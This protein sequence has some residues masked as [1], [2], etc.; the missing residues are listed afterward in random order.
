MALT[1]VMMRVPTIRGTAPLIITFSESLSRI[2]SIRAFNKSPAKP[3]V[4]QIT[5]ARTSLKIGLI[6]E[7]KRVKRRAGAASS[8]IVRGTIKPG[9]DLP[10]IYRE[11]PFIKKRMERRQMRVI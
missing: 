11:S 1:I 9:T 3:R 5:G 8:A 10:A 7:F 4:I 6:T 2:K